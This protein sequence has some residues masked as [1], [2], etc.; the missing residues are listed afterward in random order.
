MNA[1]T[2]LTVVGVDL[3]KNVFQLHFVDDETGDGK[4]P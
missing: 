4:R 1:N 2:N 3:A